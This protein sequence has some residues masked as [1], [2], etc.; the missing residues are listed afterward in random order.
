MKIVLRS[1]VIIGIAKLR[2][3]FPQMSEDKQH[4]DSAIVRAWKIK[5]IA[6]PAYAKASAGKPLR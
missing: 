3:I 1:I 4:V 5:K 6:T 2:L